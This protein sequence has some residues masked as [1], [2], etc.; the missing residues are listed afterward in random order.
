MVSA[1]L[2]RLP[3]GACPAWT[4]SNH[5]VARFPT[6]W[7][8][9]DERKT[10]LGLL[11][12][13]TLPGTLVLYY[14]DEIGMENVEIP[15]ERLLDRMTS[16]TPGRY[17]RDNARTPMQWSPAPGAGFTRPDV[18]PWLPFGDYQDRNVADETQDPSSVLSLC[19]GLLELRHQHLGPGLAT[20]EEIPAPDHQWVYRT[21]DLI[22]AANFSEEMT[23]AA[24]PGGDVLLSTTEQQRN[25]PVAGPNLQLRPWEGVIIKGG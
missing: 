10:R 8:G 5:D 9:G 4:G 21:G 13:C 15:D 19:R 25:G 2:G 14:G 16:Q 3:A 11:I 1:T 22:V 24:G 20:Y 18:R 12:L 17:R 23:S 7:A 6:R